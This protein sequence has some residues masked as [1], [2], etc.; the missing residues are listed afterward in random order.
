MVLIFEMGQIMVI[1]NNQNKAV[2][3]LFARGFP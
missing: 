1:K 2:E 3:G